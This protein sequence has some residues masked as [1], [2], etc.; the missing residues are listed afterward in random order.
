MDEVVR[1]AAASDTGELSR[2]EELAR[3]GVRDV[4]GGALR[5]QECPPVSDWAALI[6]NP[7]ALVLVGSLDGATVAFLVMRLKRDKNR[8]FISHVYVEVEGRELGLG[9]VFI[10]RA[11]SAVRAAGLSGI[12]AVALPGD[13]DTKNLFERA[14]LTA[15]KLI[16][17]KSL[18]DSA[19]PAVAPDPVP[20]GE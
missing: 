15:R 18:T 13:R 4:R 8:G 17:Y 1:C 3:N 7:D 6:A 16:V 19:P 20:D 9:D 14:G 10:E 11:I 12:E 5:L 2:L